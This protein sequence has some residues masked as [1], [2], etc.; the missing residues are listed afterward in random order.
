MID[1][2]NNT[3]SIRKQ[4]GLL[5]VNRSRIYYKAASISERDI[6]MMNFIDTEFTAHPFTGVERMVEVACRAKDAVLIIF[7]LSVFGGQSSMR[8][9][10]CESMA[11]VTN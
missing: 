8:K 2:T 1:K 11:M 10:I 6:S 4:C 3:L 7:W 5:G 9:F